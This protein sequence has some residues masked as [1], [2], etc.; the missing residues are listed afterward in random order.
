V[1][2]DVALAAVYRAA[3]RPVVCL[4]G[5]DAVRFR[6]YPD[7]LASV[8][9]G[10]TKNLA[11]GAARAG[12]WPVIGATVWVSAGLAILAAAILD[13]S[14]AVAVGW[15]VYAVEVWWMLRRLG[16]FHPLTAA[17]FPVP[18][19][20]FVVLFAR[21]ALVRLLGRPVTWRGRRLDPRRTAS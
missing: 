6:M 1:V 16:S 14:P 11:G 7:G 3:G 2:E 17:L 8:L 13:P 10:W 19:L 12:R 9:E 18:H 5:A 4:G 20:A 21:S 15:A